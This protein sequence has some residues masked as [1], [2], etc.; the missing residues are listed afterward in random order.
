MHGDISF[1]GRELLDLRQK[2]VHTYR[3][4]AHSMCR[5]FSN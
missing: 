1:G 5:C 2:I 3:Y 4:S